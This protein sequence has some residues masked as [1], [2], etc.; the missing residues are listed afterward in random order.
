[1]N[2]PTRTTRNKPN[3]DTDV[4]GIEETGCGHF[5]GLSLCFSIGQYSHPP[6]WLLFAEGECEDDGSE[7]FSFSFTIDNL[8]CPAAQ[9]LNKREAHAWC[10]G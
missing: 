3:T 8:L 10:A 1:M 5:N 4:D 9:L 7:T 6:L 2:P